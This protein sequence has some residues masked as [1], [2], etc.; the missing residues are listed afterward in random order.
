MYNIKF[1]YLIHNTLKHYLDTEKRCNFT[2]FDV[3]IIYVFNCNYLMFTLRV[4]YNRNKEIRLHTLPFDW[5]NPLG[6]YQTRLRR[7]LS[8]DTSI[9]LFLQ[10][11]KSFK[12]SRK[13]LH[14]F[15]SNVDLRLKIFFYTHMTS[16]T[17]FRCLIV[18]I[19]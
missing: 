14:C 9:H 12:N 6:N 5:K 19:L 11:D 3:Y 18:K 7:Y 1:T 13:S 15:I 17:L 16:E 4:W 8:D 10:L 2:S